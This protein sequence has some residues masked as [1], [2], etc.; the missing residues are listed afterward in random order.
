MNR[1]RRKDILS[2]QICEYEKKLKLNNHI[3]NLENM[4]AR[5]RA[6]FD[7]KTKP[8]FSRMEKELIS[9]RNIVELEIN[10]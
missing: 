1:R 10:P 7:K 5:K 6:S 2:V 9:L 8:E 4:F 3:L